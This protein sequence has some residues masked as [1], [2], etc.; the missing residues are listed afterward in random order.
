MPLASVTLASALPY[1][2]VVASV[3]MVPAFRPVLPSRSTVAVAP[4]EPVA[5][6][7]T[8]PTVRLPPLSWT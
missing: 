3:V 7:L 5:V 8:L 6:A 1:W 4:V 2:D